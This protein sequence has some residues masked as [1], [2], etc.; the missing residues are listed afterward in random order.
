MKRM[1]RILFVLGLLAF[2]SPGTSAQTPVATSGEPVAFASG[3]G[4]PATFFDDRGNPILEVVL[5]DITVDWQEYDEAYPPDRGMVY[6]KLDFS[7]T[8]LTDRAET[9]SPYSIMLIDSTGLSLSQAYVPDDPDVMIEDMPV[10]GGGTLEGSLVFAMYSDIQPMM[11]IW[12]PDFTQYVFI[13][14]GE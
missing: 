11:V 4:Q 5:T 13:H 12:Q 3:T 2:Q 14:I 7:F 6:V 8:N 10:D 1:V 9:I